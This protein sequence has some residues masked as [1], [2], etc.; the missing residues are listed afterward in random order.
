MKN[1]SYYLGLDMGTTSVGFAVTDE[2]YN[3]IRVKGKDFWGIRE[4][5]PASTSAEC[6]INRTNR[7]R[8]QREVVRI[9]LLKSFF[10]EEIAKVDPN[11][12]LRME[13]SKYYPEDKD[14]GLKTKNG[15]FDDENYTDK[16]YYEQYKTVFHLR[17]ELIE[18]KNA[19]YDVRLV[20]LA[21]LNLFK[22]RGH[23]LL[24]NVDASS[25]SIELN[26]VYDELTK[27]LETEQDIFLPKGYENEIIKI[28]SNNSV[29]RKR[30]QEELL[31][32]LK[33]DKKEKRAIEFIKILCGLSVDVT[34]LFEIE[35]EE[36]VTVCFNEASYIDKE[37]N[38]RER[39]GEDNYAV[40]D[41][42]KQIYDFAKLSSILNGYDYLSEA[43]CESYTK[44]QNDLNLLKKLYRKYLPAEYD[45]MFR[46]HESGSYSAYVKSTNAEKHLEGPKPYRR[47]MDKTKQEDLYA[48][49]KKSLKNYS[50]DSEV[51]Y[52]LEEMDKETFLPKQL[53][54]A[55]GV[56]P[57]QVHK[58]E[59]EKILKNAEEYLPFLSERDEKGYSV[60]DKIIQLFSFQIPY[61]I[62]PT[63][64]N[65]KN[66]WVVRKE[67]GMVLPW[68]LE[69]KVDVEKTSEKFITN[70]IRSCTYLNG[71][72]VLPKNSLEYEAFSV[73]NEINNLKIDGEK[74]S[75]ELKQNIY[76]DLFQKGKRVTAKSLY[77]YL[78]VNG[79]IQTEKQV[80]GIDVNI[81]NALTS[82]GKM[83]AIFGEK[84][85]EDTYKRIS[86]E[87]IY[88]G[89]IYGDSK[90]LW[91]DKLQKYV[92]KGI[93]S[94][95]DL[96]RVL[97]YKFAD[98]GR[99]SK[100]LLEIEGI[101]YST[102]ESLSLIRAMWNYNL[103]FM[104]L[105]NSENFS[106]KQSLEDK[107]KELL[108][109]LS[110]FKY[111]DLDGYYY[112]APV[113]R[114]I[115]QTI[116]VIREVEKVMGKAPQKI[117]LEMTRSDEEKGDKGRTKS[118]ANQLLEL[119]KDIKDSEKHNWKNEIQ[120][121][122]DNGKLNSK[123]LY[124][125]Y[126]Q[127][128]RDAYTGEPIDVERLYDD[129]L[130]DIDHIYPRHFV[131]DDSLLNNLVL[132]NKL[133]NEHLKKDIYPL[134]DQ[135]VQ[136][137]KVRELWDTLRAKGLMNNEKY[138]RLVSR[139]PF[140]E[141]QLAGFIARQ[142]VETS[143]AAKGIADI[144]KMLVPD[145]SIV[146]SK[147]GNVSD[148]R[149]DNGFVKSRIV[150]EF[151]HAKDAYLNIVVGNVYDTK[152]TQS[153]AN[154]IKEYVK[155]QKRN[156]YHLAKMFDKDV[157]RNGKLAWIAGEKGTILIVRKVMEKNT[158]L[159]TKLSYVNKGKLYDVKPVGKHKAKAENYAP[160][161]SNDDRMSD[162]SKYGGYTSIKPA[163]FIFIEH[164]KKGK[165]KRVFEVIS[166]LDAWKIHD[167]DSLKLYCERELGYEDVKVICEK[168]KKNAL[169]RLNGY[170]LFVT[171]MDFRK[172]IE[173]QNA[174]NLC[175]T[176]WAYKYAHSI[177][178]YVAKGKKQ[179]EINIENNKK[180]YQILKSRHSGKLFDKSPKPIGK[181][182][183]NGE[184]K[185][186]KLSLEEQVKVLYDLL[187]IT[188]IGRGGVD[189]KIIG[190]SSESGRMRISGNMTKCQE[191]LLINQSVTGIYEKQIKLV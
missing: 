83:Y 2:Q 136:N 122:F 79:Y 5:D 78:S 177:E 189:L 42:L 19:P 147:A 102:G 113:K 67:E 1:K 29:S 114:M 39:I 17:K 175:L 66:G 191:L 112:S 110:D 20:F 153:P 139:Q 94:E 168:I 68:N 8:H 24:N 37:P 148:F 176:G 36:K 9:G 71:E 134:P 47:N 61:Y 156:N 16:E 90:K 149:R 95:K 64:S 38:I 34:K 74:I 43:R 126:L 77:C 23:F 131:K 120:E 188:S 82:Y 70:L 98:W 185:F 117:F 130:Y 141:S 119:Y 81:N 97:G 35:A 92:E 91:K 161:K 99:L 125:Y 103:N 57:N 26:L 59:L 86:E 32:L 31:E 54:G 116:L 181:M 80:S 46:S 15:L 121:A 11:F 75:P 45:E 123:K 28:L 93:I 167:E 40:I 84:L 154:F 3:L 169:I 155:D 143:Q 33:V 150:N 76:K 166:G 158:P 173:F 159:M 18:N 135:I 127:M 144:I 190:G 30:K 49:I 182:L 137:S 63:S 101:D 58:K 128:G 162:V 133:A 85:E 165:R 184:N 13:N 56:I 6:R 179:S 146:Y 60:S 55:N 12:Y 51:Q 104:E 96:K 107:R 87:I 183:H 152:F 163:Y 170:Y 151:H 10:E 73:L 115:W 186:E 89:T 157:A 53:T 7:R 124:L 138:G 69:E 62:G 25:S 4:F 187:T 100:A 172:N 132:V 44:H 178:N 109:T 180:L 14:T 111:E 50:D 171:G 174:T 52:V 41:L 140:T 48:T 27:T 108:M 88:W 129:N 105:I 118:R 142:L 22:H 145:T 21:I 65:S 72:K 106:F 160:I 164:G